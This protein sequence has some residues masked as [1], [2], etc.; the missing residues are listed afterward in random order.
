MVQI[1]VPGHIVIF[2]V[3]CAH[4][5]ATII[6]FSSFLL[7]NFQ[8]KFQP[9]KVIICFKTCFWRWKSWKSKK[10]RAHSVIQLLKVSTGGHFQDSNY[11]IWL[12]Y[13]GLFLVPFYAPVLENSN[14]QWLEKCSE[15]WIYN[16][17]FLLPI[18]GPGA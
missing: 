17:Y 12:K 8:K 1:V 16:V 2:L 13:P 14:S 10:L 6:Q 7:I 15:G 5:T 18:K 3:H 4:L 9:K 11:M